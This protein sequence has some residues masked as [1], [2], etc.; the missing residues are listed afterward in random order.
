MTSE[1]GPLARPYRAVRA[2][3]APEDGPWP[4]VL[5]R[6]TAGESRLLVDAELLG[7]EW[8][9]WDAAADGHLLAPLDIVRRPDG[10]DVVLPVCVERLHDFLRRRTARMPLGAGEAVTLG[11]GLL[12]G[13]EEIAGAAEVIG[14][15]WLDEAGRPVLATD[16]TEERALHSAAAAFELVEVEPAL[17]RTWQTG[18]RALTA[19][20]VSATELAACEDALFAVADAEP[21]STVTL[22]PRG[23]FDGPARSIGGFD[24]RLADAPQPPPRAMWQSLI[25]GMDDDLADSVSRATT[26]VWRRPMKPRLTCPSARCSCGSASAWRALSLNCGEVV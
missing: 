5:A 12:R 11:V 16:V 13:C 25:A 19:E 8:K 14:E 22:A 21:L 2:V 7:A 4:G 6:T 26:A 9:G 23:A 20:R 17:R 3:R 10:H 24:T 18:L 15:W 1:D